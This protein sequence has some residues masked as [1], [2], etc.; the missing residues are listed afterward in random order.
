MGLWKLEYHQ[1]ARFRD[2]NAWLQ[3]VEKI[4]VYDGKGRFQNDQRIGPFEIL[5]T[6]S[7]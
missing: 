1:K 3:S 5:E 2:D 6:I 4:Q 7:A